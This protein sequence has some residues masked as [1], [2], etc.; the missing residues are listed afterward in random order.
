MEIIYVNSN[1]FIYGS[2]IIV[3]LKEVDL[4][5]LTEIIDLETFIDCYFVNVIGIM[6]IDLFIKQFWF[7]L[8]WLLI[9]IVYTVYTIYLL[10]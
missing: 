7:E 3:D 1:V 2:R 8:N 10:N 6:Y 5:Y 4:W 9:D